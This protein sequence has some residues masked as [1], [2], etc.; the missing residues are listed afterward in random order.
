[1]GKHNLRQ[2][3]NFQRQISV[4]RTII[5]PRYNPNT[6]DNDIMLVHLKNKVEFSQKIQPLPLRKDCFEEKP[7]CQILGWGKME[8]G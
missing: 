6:H 2:T 5:H 3:E 1:M 4:D 8:N 7:R